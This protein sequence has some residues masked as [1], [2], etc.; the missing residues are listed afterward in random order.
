MS[1][2]IESEEGVLE[3]PELYSAVPSLEA[4]ASLAGPGVLSEADRAGLARAYEFAEQAHQGQLRASGA[5]YF[6]HA[7]QVALE[8]SRIG[9]D[10]SS[11]AAGLLHDTLEDTNT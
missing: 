7:A 9:L 10:A 5:P 11:M 1:V 8:L 6:S 3:G 2:I 4:I